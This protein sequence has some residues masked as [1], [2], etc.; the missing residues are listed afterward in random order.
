[1]VNQSLLSQYARAETAKQ[2]MRALTV[3]KTQVLLNML[4]GV[5]MGLILGIFMTGW[6]GG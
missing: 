5:V 4:A 2:L 1:M 3:S 6:L